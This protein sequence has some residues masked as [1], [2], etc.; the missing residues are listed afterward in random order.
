MNQHNRHMA[1]GAAT[2]LAGAAALGYVGKKAK[3]YIDRRKGT[4]VSGADDDLDVGAVSGSTKT[5]GM[6]LA[7]LEA[8]RVV[9]PHW[10]DITMGDLTITV[11]TDCLRASP[12]SG[13][14]TYRLPVTYPETIKIAKAYDSIAPTKE[15]CDAIYEH[16][17]FKTVFHSLVL[18]K[19]DP[20]KM[21][22]LE[23]TRKYNKDI[24]K[25]LKER[26]EFKTFD[27]QSGAE[28]YWILNKRLSETVQGAPAAINYGGWDAKGKPKQ[29]VGGAHNIYHYDYSQLYRPVKRMAKRG[30]Q[31][32][33]LLD[34]IR[35]NQDVPAQ[36]VDAF[37]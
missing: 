34:W 36:F 31:E 1:I 29:K 17:L 33:D 23:F 25:Q 3:E 11:A 22:T 32:V 27:F 6:L 16:A 30:S 21:T 26:P 19:A 20:A 9:P 8:D 12:G 24:E 18:G 15:I 5:G 7:A 10:T 35:D 14:K 2:L 13:E 4:R 37:R 28:K